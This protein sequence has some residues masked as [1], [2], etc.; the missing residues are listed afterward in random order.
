M[1]Y[2]NIIHVKLDVDTILPYVHVAIN[3]KKII[4]LL[5]EQ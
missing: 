5:T 2:S 3:S 4:I 1:I